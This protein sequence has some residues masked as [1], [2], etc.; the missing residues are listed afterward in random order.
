MR[1]TTWDI[2]VS[3]ETIIAASMAASRGG[4]LL[5]NR[6]GSIASTLIYELI[7]RVGI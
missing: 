5:V 6:E 2:G 4:T 7:M 3:G 1:S